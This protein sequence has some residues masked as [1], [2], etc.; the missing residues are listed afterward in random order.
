MRNGLRGDAAG[1]FEAGLF[2]LSIVTLGAVR[3]RRNQ[4]EATDVGMAP[5]SVARHR[6]TRRA[7][8]QPHA[9]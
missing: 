9:R 7:R 2:F 8:S 5:A 6:S 4:T 3:E 1:N